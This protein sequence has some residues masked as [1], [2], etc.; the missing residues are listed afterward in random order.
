MYKEIK[1][2]FKI[3]P[4]HI[5]KDPFLASFLCATCPAHPTILELITLTIFGQEY[6]L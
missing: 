4:K 2:Y 1:V 5:R 6:K 3:L